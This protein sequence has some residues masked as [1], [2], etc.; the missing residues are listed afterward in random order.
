MRTY[1]ILQK[2][3]TKGDTL[4]QQTSLEAYEFILPE[5]AERQQEIFE[6]IQ[7][8][9]GMSNHDISRFLNVEINCVT[10]RVN[11]LRDKH[12]VGLHGQK[13]DRI[14]NRT[15]NTWEVLV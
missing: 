13:T 14:T 2:T 4:I 1:K 5:L 15:V 12:M 10:P 8:H 6:V 9:P 3:H 11:E 7:R